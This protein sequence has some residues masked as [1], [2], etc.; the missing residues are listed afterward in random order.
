MFEFLRNI[1]STWKMCATCPMINVTPD[2]IYI[3]SVRFYRRYSEENK[4][5]AIATLCH[6]FCVFMFSFCCY[7]F[8]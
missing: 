1:V 4:F 7:T 6:T 3:H 2:F 5:A 8:R